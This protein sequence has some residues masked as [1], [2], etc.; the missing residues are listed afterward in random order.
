MLCLILCS[1]LS[2]HYPHF[3]SEEELIHCI[4]SVGDLQ[5]H[6]EGGKRSLLS[7]ILM[8]WP[9]LQVGGTLLPHLIELYQWLHNKIA[10]SL[11]YN[12]ALTITIGKVIATAE[13][14]LPKKSRGHYKSLYEQ[15]QRDFNHYVKLTGITK[16]GT[17]GDKRFFIA[18][19]TPLIHFL[20]GKVLEGTSNL[21][22]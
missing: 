18:D 15:V 6:S 10:H 21:M 16:P 20:T 8:D 7:K 12:Q 22:V 17:R 11:T 19:D 9:L 3:P 14:N 13:R 1:H 4:L 2:T 5:Q